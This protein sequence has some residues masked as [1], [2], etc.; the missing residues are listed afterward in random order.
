[1][2]IEMVIGQNK[3]SGE[4]FS[5]TLPCQKMQLITVKYV[6][7]YSTTSGA[8]QLLPKDYG[9]RVRASVLKNFDGKMQFS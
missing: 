6:F 7:D 2:A 9:I 1:M 8:F 4:F 5:H 3:R